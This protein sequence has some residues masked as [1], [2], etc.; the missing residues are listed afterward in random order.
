M[1]VFDFRQKLVNEYA[2]FTHNFKRVKS[3]DIRAFVDGEYASKKYKSKRLVQVSQNFQPGDT[4]KHI[5]SD[6]RGQGHW[7]QES[8]VTLSSDNTVCLDVARLIKK[9][10]KATARQQIKLRGRILW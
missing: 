7:V 4:V 6:E 1:N 10:Y 9:W 2:E 8:P 5:P 3:Y